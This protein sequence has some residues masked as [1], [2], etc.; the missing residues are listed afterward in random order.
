MLLSLH[1]IHFYQ[2]L[3]RAMRSAIEEN[4]FEAW[5]TEFHAKR[6]EQ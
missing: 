4:R 6:K 3:M 2:D 5:R 1:N